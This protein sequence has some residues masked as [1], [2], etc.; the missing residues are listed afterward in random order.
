MEVNPRMLSE[1]TKRLSKNLSFKEK[2]IMTYRPYICPFH[3]LIDFVP[4][5]S[6][7]LDVGCG[8]GLW[9]YLLWE[10]KLISQG[11][12]IEIDENK[13]KTALS[14]KKQ[15]YNLDFKFYSGKDG[16][17]CEHFDCVSLIDVIHH[18][19][20]DDQRSFI[21]KIAAINTELIIFKDINPAS[22]TKA[23]MNSL[24]DLVLSQ[25]KP[26][27]CRI[28]DISTWLKEEGF[29]TQEI[30]RY[31]MLWYSHYYVIARRR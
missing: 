11:L 1:I 24:H 10:L 12:G 17:P 5:N 13:V 7:I 26:K 6:K 9:L 28:E 2:F 8:S 14:L 16:F 27:Y 30:S 31:D 23:A 15:N 18:I 22:R 20:K 4:E 29:A 19:P 25:Q 21:K 3:K